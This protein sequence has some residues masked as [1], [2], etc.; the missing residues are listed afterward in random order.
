MRV[1]I[2]GAGALGSVYG[3]RLRKFAACDVSVVARAPAPASVMRLERV[4][5]VVS[6]RPIRHLFGRRHDR[7]LGARV[8]ADVLHDY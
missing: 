8:I 5:D 4:E 1:A 2:V 3:A 6:D 7:R